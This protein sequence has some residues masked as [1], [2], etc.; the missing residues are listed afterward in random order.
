MSGCGCDNPFAV[1]PRQLG[2]FP[3]PERF[4]PIQHT[5]SGSLIG[6][7]QPPGLATAEAHAA[8][9]A[10]P[11]LAQVLEAYVRRKLAAGEPFWITDQL[12]SQALAARGL[13]GLGFFAEIAAAISSAVGAIGSVVGPAAQVAAA[14]HTIEGVSGGGGSSSSSAG[15]TA[16]QIA[17]AILPQVQQKLAAQGVTLPAD[18]AH[19][20]VSASIL[21]A[22]GPQYRPLVTAGLVV[23]GVA[24]LV[25]VLRR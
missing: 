9:Q 20:A 16:D 3:R 5:A 15:V 21:D 18:V 1:A 24:L 11:R 13:K 7:F 6:A 25:K 14:V 12:N 23:L 4:G 2:G 19:Q 10:S 17:A 22:F 8:A